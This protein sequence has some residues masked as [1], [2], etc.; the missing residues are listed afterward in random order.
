MNPVMS[1]YYGDS[2]FMIAAAFSVRL[3]S[4]AG[5]PGLDQ[6]GDQ[7]RDLRRIGDHDAPP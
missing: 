5:E 7:D 3:I 2:I 1:L 6:G 4:A